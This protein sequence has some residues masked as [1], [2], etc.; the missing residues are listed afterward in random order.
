MLYDYRKNKTR[1]QPK[2]VRFNEYEATELS[3]S[4]KHYHG[5]SWDDDR[6]IESKFI[7]FLI[8]EYAKSNEIV[9]PPHQST[10]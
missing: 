10:V 3:L 7:R 9:V 4:A 8:R 6:G 5:D 2:M 1:D